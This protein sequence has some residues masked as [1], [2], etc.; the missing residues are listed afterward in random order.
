MLFAFPA[1]PVRGIDCYGSDDLP[2]I[3]EE[4]VADELPSEVLISSWRPL[5]VIAHTNHSNMSYNSY[6][7]H[8]HF[9]YHHPYHHHHIIRDNDYIC[10]S[11]RPSV[12]EG[13]QKRFDLKPLHAISL[14]Y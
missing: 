4:V 12:T 7:L 13:Q 9:L 11:V 2:A 1:S 10:P 8:V 5:F 6:Q 14:A 3:P